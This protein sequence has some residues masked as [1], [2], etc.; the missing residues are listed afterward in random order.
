MRVAIEDAFGFGV[1]VVCVGDRAAA[2]QMDLKSFELIICDLHANDGHGFEFLVDVKRRCNTPIILV[3]DENVGHLVVESIRKGAT[4]YVVKTPDYLEALP[5][6]IQ[7]NLVMANICK[8]NESLRAELE[9]VLQ[10]VCEKNTQLER[11]LLLV[12]ELAATDP[13]TN[14]FN[15]RY[16]S[17]MLGH[18]FGEARRYKMPLSCVM[19]DLDKFKQ[20]NDTLG[21]QTGDELVILA[22]KAITDNLRKVDIAA[23][24]GGDEFIVLLPHTSAANAMI[25]AHRIRNQFK[26]ASK[27]Q[28]NLEVC[29]TMS[30]GV[31]E[32]TPQTMT[33]PEHLVLHADRGLYTAKANGR[34]CVCA[35]NQIADA[36]RLLS[37]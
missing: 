16:F 34:D 2:L 35:Y 13:L 31:A 7:K 1:S 28:F 25:V 33:E 21:H 18:C 20:L 23:R 3:T 8:E 12:E 24:Y 17:R 19:I 29:A 10:E 11:S 30:I 14:L 15:R 6:V 9:R 4:D 5:V 22:A 36:A 32:L 37:A 26:P 27:L